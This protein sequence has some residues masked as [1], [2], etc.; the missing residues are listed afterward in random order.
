MFQL[1]PA[2]GSGAN[3]RPDWRYALTIKEGAKITAE[4]DG[5]IEFSTN[6]KVRFKEED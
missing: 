2:I 6:Q 5:E 4:S 1:V 3:V